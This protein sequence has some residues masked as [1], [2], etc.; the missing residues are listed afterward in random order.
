MRCSIA[1]AAG[2]LAPDD[3]I[4]L[5]DVLAGRREDAE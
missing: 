3:A 4:D 5:L 1:L 2:L